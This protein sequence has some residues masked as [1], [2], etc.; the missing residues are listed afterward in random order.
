MLASEGLFCG[1]PLARAAVL[2]DTPPDRMMSGSSCQALRHAV[3]SLNRLDDFT[4]DKIGSGFFSEVYKVR[5]TREIRKQRDSNP[6]PDQEIG[7]L[8][9]LKKG[10]NCGEFWTLDQLGKFRKQ[11]LCSYFEIANVKNLSE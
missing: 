1:Q 2:Q 10:I 4:T 7:P 6:R 11:A 9:A 3:A 5:D 8:L